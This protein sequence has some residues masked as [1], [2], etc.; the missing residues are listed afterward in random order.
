VVELDGHE[1]LLFCGQLPLDINR[2]GSD[3]TLRFGELRLFA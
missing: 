1:G 2:A 3:F